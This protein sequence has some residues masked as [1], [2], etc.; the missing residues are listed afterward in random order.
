MRLSTTS[1]ALALLL[2]SGGVAAVAHPGPTKKVRT[3]PGPS[4]ATSTALALSPSA[5]SSSSSPRPLLGR[6]PL[7]LAN[8]CAT[9]L[10]ERDIARLMQASR[11]DLARVLGKSG[12]R[13]LSRRHSLAP[14]RVDF[15]EEGARR[16]SYAGHRHLE[17]WGMD[18]RIHTWLA[19]NREAEIVDLKHAPGNVYSIKDLLMLG[20]FPRLTRLTVNVDIDEFET[21]YPAAAP[22]G[23]ATAPLAA[24]TSLTLDS[25]EHYIDCS[26]LDLAPLLAGCRLRHLDL[27]GCALGVEGSGSFAQNLYKVLPAHGA[28]LRSLVVNIEGIHEDEEGLNLAAAL[29]DLPGLRHLAFVDSNIAHTLNPEV[30]AALGASLSRMTA[31]ESLD[32]FGMVEA[33]DPERGCGIFK[34]LPPSLKRLHEVFEIDERGPEGNLIPAAPFLRAL[35]RLPALEELSFRS[36]LDLGV[37][38]AL[39]DALLEKPSFRCLKIRFEAEEDG[40]EEAIR[41]SLGLLAETF[42]K[43]GKRLEFSNIEG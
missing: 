34:N 28:S 15:G 1:W 12:M 3:S 8:H 43:A 41:A 29:G 16:S 4:P 35:D 22:E 42:E 33:S 39:V 14:T 5:S 27:G 23:P 30:R 36:P 18:E 10:D 21:K 25:D 24:L 7:D 6:M 20:R 9:F 32:C 31:L 19:D 38:R 40:Q 11:A 17:L 2:L 26:D 37:T 13:M